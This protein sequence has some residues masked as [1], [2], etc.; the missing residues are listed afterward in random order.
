VNEFWVS[1]FLI[2]LNGVCMTVW[3]PAATS[4]TLE[5]S[6][7]FRGSLMSLNDASRNFG[8]AFGV[9]VGGFLLLNLG[10]GFSGLILG[11]FGVFAS[12]L[13]YVFTIDPTN[14]KSDTIQK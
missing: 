6:P 14:V 13:Y 11:S 7:G 8:L 4:L 1:A 10:Y 3:Y 5:Q 2:T 9:G 12:I